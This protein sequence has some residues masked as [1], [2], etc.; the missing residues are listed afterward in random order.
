MSIKS[1]SKNPEGIW[2]VFF[3]GGFHYKGEGKKN[4]EIFIKEGHGFR[5]LRWDELVLLLEGISPKIKRRKRYN[6]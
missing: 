2:E 4:N 5:S 1:L 6:L 3:E